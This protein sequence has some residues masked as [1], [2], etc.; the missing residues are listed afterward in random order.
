MNRCT[1]GGL[2]VKHLEIFN[3]EK[4]LYEYSPIS[5]TLIY[6]DEG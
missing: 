1:N 4:M 3:D 6:I 5:F 2:I